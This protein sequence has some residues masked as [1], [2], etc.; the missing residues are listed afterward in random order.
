[1]KKESSNKKKLNKKVNGEGCIIKRK[2]GLYMGVA[3]IGRDLKGKL[4]RKYVYGKT[5]IETHK[6]LTEVQSKVYKGVFSEPSEIELN[7]WLITWMD[8]YKK[9]DILQQTKILYENIIKSIIN[10]TLGELKLKNITQMHIQMFFN[11]ISEKYSSST[12]NKVKNIL[13][14]AFQ[15]AVINKLIPETPFNNIN[16]ASKKEKKKIKC[17]NEEEIERFE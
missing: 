14:P 1:M 4:V 3:T 10:P 9:I 12:L 16:L 17:L 7:Q 11:N 13:N 6:K 15:I 2:D 5:K 8:T